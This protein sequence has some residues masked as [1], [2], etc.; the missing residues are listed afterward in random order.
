MDAEKDAKSLE[1]PE[2][3]LDPSLPSVGRDH[4]SDALPPHQSY[5]GLHRYDV[6]AIWTA[7]EEAAVVR[8][9]DMYLLSWL[10]LMVE[11]LNH[12]F[13]RFC[14]ELTK[15]PVL[16]SATGSRQSLQCLDGQFAR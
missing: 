1:E 12:D 15:H 7:K 5:E 6:A 9:T 10:C 4:L 14:F 8:K 2:S 16:R 13:A 3:N 11:K